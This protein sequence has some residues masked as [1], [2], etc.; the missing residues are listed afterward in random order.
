MGKCA[1]SERYNAKIHFDY[2]G[3]TLMAEIRT[4]ANIFPY[5]PTPTHSVRKIHTVE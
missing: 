5:I 4:A 3:I 2:K 1:E